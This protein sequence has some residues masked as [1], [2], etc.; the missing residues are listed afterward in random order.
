M[1]LIE[2]FGDRKL[3]DI[4]PDDVAFYLRQRLKERARIHTVAAW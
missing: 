1:L 4:A 2:A 3:A